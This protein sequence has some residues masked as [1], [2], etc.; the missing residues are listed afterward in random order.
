MAIAPLAAGG[1]IAR[2]QLERPDEASRRAPQ[3][4]LPAPQ[5]P[6]AAAEGASAAAPS[7]E[8]EIPPYA[9]PNSPPATGLEAFA[10]FAATRAQPTP[11]RPQLSALI[12]PATLLDTPARLP[13]GK[14]PPAVVI[15]L[16]PGTATLDLNDPPRAAPGL[17]EALGRI[18]GAGITVFWSSALPIKQADRLYAVLRAVGLDLDG[19]DRLLLP[20]KASE[21]KQ[22]RRLAAAREW[23]FVALA[24]DRRGDFE[25]ALDYLRDPAG[26]IAQAM[27]PL[28]GQ[29]WFVIPQPID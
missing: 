1:A 15:D 3:V 29:G 6:V 10:S 12:D 8:A 7:A 9:R 24:G 22:E 4:T 19:T 26:P 16:D 20:R 27:A 18:R 23:C 25:E 14:V 21:R 13:C 17:A 28:D 11:D 5:Q 2:K